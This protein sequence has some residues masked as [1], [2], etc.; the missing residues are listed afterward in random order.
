M[1][2]HRCGLFAKIEAQYPGEALFPL[3]IEGGDTMI[4][5]RKDNKYVTG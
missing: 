1:I 2:T 3:G 5:R 4:L